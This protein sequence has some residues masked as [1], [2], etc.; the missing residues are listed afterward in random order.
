MT[1]RGRR[2]ID[3]ILDESFLSEVSSVPLEELR[4]RRKECEDVEFVLS[5]QRRWLHGK[6]DILGAEIERRDPAAQRTGLVDRLSHILSDA[7]PSRRG[8]RV[9]L[10][11]EI[12]SDARRYLDRLVSEDHLA[13]LPEL[14]E[15][16][17]TALLDR[18]AQAEAEVSQN[19]KEVLRI[20]DAL[21]EEIVRRY[22]DGAPAPGVP[23][24]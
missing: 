8:A 13:R 17:L 12:P 19:R 5:Y 3:K 16:E 23:R 6:L 14:G 20:I 1:T 18:L 7:T 21:Q 10:R 4:R 2:Q 11:A 15:D 9:R 24:R 22:R